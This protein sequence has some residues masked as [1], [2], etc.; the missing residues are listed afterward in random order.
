MHRSICCIY[1][2]ALIHYEHSPG[3]TDAKVGSAWLVIKSMP[4]DYA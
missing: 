3:G 1:A 4:V 2:I